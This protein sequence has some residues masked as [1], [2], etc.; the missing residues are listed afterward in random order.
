MAS[1]HRAPLS[2]AWDLAL[3]GVNSAKTIAA[4]SA[5]MASPHL[6]GA[7]MRLMGEEKVEAAWLGAMAAQQAFAALLL[8]GTF[9]ELGTPAE[10][11]LG[12]GAVADAAMRPTRTKARANARR[13]SGAATIWR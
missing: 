13:L 1:K 7:E 11:A 3:L 6:H 5:M 9:G 10:V 2:W 12:L 8:K 4:R